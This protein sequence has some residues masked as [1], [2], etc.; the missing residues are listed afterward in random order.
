[1]SCTNQYL[2]LQ[3]SKVISAPPRHVR[4]VPPSTVLSMPPPFPA[5]EW[6]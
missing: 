5:Q 2:S 6:F 3:A 1:M 4:P